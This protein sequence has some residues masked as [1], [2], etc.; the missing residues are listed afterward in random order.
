MNKTLT[1]SCNEMGQE[2]QTNLY[3][4]ISV[5]NSRKLSTNSELTRTE[6]FTWEDFRGVF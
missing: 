4:R 6:V 5:K 1:I 2:S 3:E